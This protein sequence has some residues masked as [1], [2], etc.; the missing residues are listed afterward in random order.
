MD[1]FELFDLLEKLELKI[2]VMYRNFQGIFQD[3]NETAELFKKMGEDEESHVD[4][5]KFQRKIL[6]QG[7]RVK[8]DVDLVE[9]NSVFSK[10]EKIM[11]LRVNE[12]VNLYLL[13]HTSKDFQTEIFLIS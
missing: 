2:S 3:D 8:V 11:G 12:W 6:Q 13:E 4:I 7:V 5:V 1:I 10:I 9:I